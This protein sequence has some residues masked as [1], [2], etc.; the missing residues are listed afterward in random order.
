MKRGHKDTER[1]RKRRSLLGIRVR[2]ELET[3][4]WSIRS[5]KQVALLREEVTSI[6]FGDVRSF[7]SAPN[8]FLVLSRVARGQLPQNSDYSLRNRPLFERSGF[9]FNTN[10]RQDNAA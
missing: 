9:D 4:T 2:A 10:P 8:P 3:P 5:P 7:F 6:P 1:N